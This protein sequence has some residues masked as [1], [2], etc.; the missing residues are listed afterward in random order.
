MAQFWLLNHIKHFINIISCFLILFIGSWSPLQAQKISRSCPSDELFKNEL[1]QNPEFKKTRLLI[2][3]HQKTFIPGQGFRNNLIIVPVVV[4]VVYN[5][6]EQDIPDSLIFSQIEI[7]NTDFG[8]IQT[9]KY[10]Q[11]GASKLKFQLAT[12]DPQGNKTN[13]ITRTSTS[14][15]KFKTGALIM[16]SE[17][18]G[19]DPWPLASY[20]NIWVGNL[21]GVLGF[22]YMPGSRSD[23][24]VISYQ[25]FGRNN[26]IP[27]NLGR[28]TTHEVG[29]WLNLYHTWGLSTGCETDDEVNDTPNSAGPNYGCQTDHISCVDTDMVE[30]YMDYSDDA[31]MNL[32]TEGQVQRMEALFSPGGIRSS[33]LTTHGLDA[34]K[35]I[36]LSIP[37]ND[38]CTNGIRDN[39][40]T[41]I[42]CGGSCGPCPC[43]STGIFSMFDFIE[44]IKI[45]DS[46]SITGD[47]EGIHTDYSKS[48]DLYT[49]TS[50]SIS[51]NPGA[52]DDPGWEFWSVWVD[53][54]KDG[55]FGQE[56]L[57]YR[58]YRLGT[59][60][61]TIDLRKIFKG[62]TMPSKDAYKL[63]TQLQWGNYGHGCDTFD[64]GEV[65]NYIVVLK[66]I[67]IDP[68]TNGIKDGTETGID[69]GPACKPCA[70]RYCE[71]KG[72]VSKY[73]FVQSVTLNNWTNTSGNNNGYID[74]TSKS[75]KVNSGKDLSY[76]LT[77]GFGGNYSL[78]ENWYVWAD[79]NQDGDFVDPGEKLLETT[80]AIPIT[81]TWSIPGNVDGPVRLRVQMR[82]SKKADACDQFAYG[83]VEDYEL[84]IV[85]TAFRIFGI[86]DQKV[87]I[88]T[89]PN[90]VSQSLHISIPSLED[91]LIQ[92]SLINEL[93]QVYYSSSLNNEL[94]Q[95]IDCSRIPQGV[96]SL[97]F[98]NEK[99]KE[100]KRIIIVH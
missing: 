99:I 7:L 44:S 6:P 41:G 60:K 22:A 100:S 50:N 18:G 92:I 28:T 90:P 93:G 30:N 14:T 94:I 80:S 86:S 81:G 17:Y 1:I 77:A 73:E 42:D 61:D 27:F 12:S 95:T 25:F 82:D 51:L 49:N 32:F 55:F 23:G 79:W 46:I 29:H 16:S 37:I 38:P 63:R 78:T 36:V 9:E 68:C 21:S 8:Q 33:I 15:T 11:A 91:Q 84:T 43:N 48:F 67:F 56:E 26:T 62:K 96:Y 89:F 47:N 66:E 5:T 75:I 58:N 97:I 13:G 35:D 57:V 65:E 52:S 19:T 3:Q 45:N 20:L 85:K 54:N 10:P 2:D 69:C 87:I 98:S 31:C 39:N 70:Q 64:F 34:G 74:F 53:W 76:T 59:I 40:E 88:N 24:V 83:E 71:S 4:H 72:K